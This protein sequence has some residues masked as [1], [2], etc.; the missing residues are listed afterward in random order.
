MACLCLVNCALECSPRKFP[1]LPRLTRV[2]LET[3]PRRTV[4]TVDHWTHLHDRMGSAHCGRGV[5]ERMKAVVRNNAPAREAS[6]TIR[7]QPTGRVG[8]TDRATTH[9]VSWGGP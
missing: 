4:S 6:G 1:Y 8:T 5:G 7:R 9:G 3:P 2:F